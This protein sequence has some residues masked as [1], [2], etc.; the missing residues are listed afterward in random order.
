MPLF[1][2][3]VLPLCLILRAVIIPIQFV[4]SLGIPCHLRKLSIW[5]ESYGGHYV[6]QYAHYVEEQNDLIAASK[7]AAPAVSIYVEALGL[8]NVCIDNDVQTP[9]CPEFA[10]NNTYGIKTINESQYQS[11]KAATEQCLKLSSECR[12]LADAQDP[13]G[14]G[15]NP[16]VSD[17]CLEAYLY[18][19]SNMHDDF[20][21][22]VRLRTRCC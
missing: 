18:C 6:A 14:V 2:Q 22:T 9:L 19:F 13:K 10:V 17:A 21:K 3:F 1:V 5:G 4:S 15:N 20:D 12:S 11:A 7:L 8:L 16:D